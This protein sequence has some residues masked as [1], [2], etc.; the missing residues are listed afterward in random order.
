MRVWVFLPFW[1]LRLRIRLSYG[2]I[3]GVWYRPQIE[4]K[5]W[6][7]LIA[8]MTGLSGPKETEKL[9]RQTIR[10]EIDPV[11]FVKPLLETIEKTNDVH[12]F[13]PIIY[14]AVTSRK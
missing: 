10:T 7:K 8:D 6:A 14:S 2:L 12:P 13:K 5:K 1:V 9:T 4:S 3:I 11:G